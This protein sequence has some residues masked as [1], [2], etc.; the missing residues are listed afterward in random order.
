[1][2]IDFLLGFNFS[3]K[4]QKN[5]KTQQS[6]DKTLKSIQIINIHLKK[7]KEDDLQNFFIYII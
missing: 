2:S 7:R 4:N 5:V 3:V 1:M 6:L